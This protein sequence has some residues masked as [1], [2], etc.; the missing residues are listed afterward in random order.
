M[1]APC[2]AS[3][4]WESKSL[5]CVGSEAAFN[6][7]IRPFGPTTNGSDTAFQFPSSSLSHV[8]PSSREMSEPFVP[9]VIQALSPSLHATAER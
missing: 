6:R 5:Q 2:L 1:G 8:F 9:T 4:T 7:A 3:E